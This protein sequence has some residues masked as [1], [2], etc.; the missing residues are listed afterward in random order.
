MKQTSKNI[1]LTSSI[2]VLIGIVISLYFII[3][4]ENKDFSENGI[5]VTATILEKQ[6]IDDDHSTK[7]V[8]MR[9]VFRI[10][11]FTEPETQEKNMEVRPDSTE[12]NK[13]EID[14]KLDDIFGD[15]NRERFGD[16]STTEL[17]VNSDKYLQY[18]VGDKIRITYLKDSP[19]KVRIAE[20]D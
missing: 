17:N 5:S 15:P 3:R 20:E 1:I 7:R 12:T 19:A 11:Y 2:I 4:S 10:S 14:K 8:K 18:N 6:E 13:S 16:Y 9:Y